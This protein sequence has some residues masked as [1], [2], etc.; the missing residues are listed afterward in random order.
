MYIIRPREL[1][2]SGETRGEA[3]DR[4]IHLAVVDLRV[5]NLVFSDNIPVDNRCFTIDD[6]GIVTVLPV[7][8]YHEKI[9]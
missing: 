5:T 2:Y 7:E 6:V 1:L 4:N 3:I 9:L 8:D